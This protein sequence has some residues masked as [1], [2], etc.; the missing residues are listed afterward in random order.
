MLNIETRSRT[1]E[2]RFLNPVF[3]IAGVIFVM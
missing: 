3:D 2:F 1:F